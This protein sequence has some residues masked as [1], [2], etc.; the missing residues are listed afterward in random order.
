MRAKKRH[1]M[2]GTPTHN[3][4]RTMVDRCTRGLDK[5]YT[6]VSVDESWLS[7]DAFFS[8]M[9]VRP[10]GMTLDRKD[11]TKGYSKDNCRWASQSV[12]QQNKAPSKRNRNG[13]PGVFKSHNKFMARIQV[14]GKKI[15]LGTFKTAVEAHN[16]YDAK[17]R[18]LFGDEWVSYKEDRNDES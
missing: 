16:V 14:D 13:F 4:W 2:Y 11:F 8:D 12:Q 18:E 15:Y 9:G 3:S 5:N 1:G 7:F 17:G 10:N 6:G